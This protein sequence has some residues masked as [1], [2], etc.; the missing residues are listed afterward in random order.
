MVFD[1]SQIKFVSD[2]YGIVHVGYFIE[3]I[4]TEYLFNF[5]N[6]T[7]NQIIVIDDMKKEKMEYFI[8]ENNFSKDKY[9]F[10]CLDIKN[11]ILLELTWVEGLLNCFDYIYI[12]LYQNAELYDDIDKYLKKFNLK[13]QKKIL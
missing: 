6:V 12:N 13:I 2:V 11:N 5:H 7:N 10:L 8:D 9:N 1:F 3:E 4:R